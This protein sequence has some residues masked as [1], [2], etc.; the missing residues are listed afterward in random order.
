MNVGSVGSANSPGAQALK[1]QSEASEVQKGGRDGD[2]DSD[3]GSSK[4]V[5][6]PAPTVNMNGQKIGQ[7]INASA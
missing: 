3:D 5:Q 2:G 6:A 1:P 4:P 7:I